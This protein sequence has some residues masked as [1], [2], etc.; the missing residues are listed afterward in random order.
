MNLGDPSPKIPRSQKM[1]NLAQKGGVKLQ[2]M[3]RKFE[4]KTSHSELLNIISY[5]QNKIRNDPKMNHLS[6]S[7]IEL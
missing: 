2:K 4:F 1:V 6:S 5:D 7:M 3:D